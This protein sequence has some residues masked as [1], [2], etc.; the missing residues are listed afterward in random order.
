[1]AI[2]EAK[3]CSGLEC[4]MS[5]LT[6]VTVTLFQHCASCISKEV[7]RII[8]IGWW[9][10]LKSNSTLAIFFRRISS[11][12][13]QLG[14]L[15][16]CVWVIRVELFALRVAFDIQMFTDWFLACQ[17]HCQVPKHSSLIVW[18]TEGQYGY[19]VLKMIICAAIS[20]IGLQWKCECSTKWPKTEQKKI[21]QLNAIL[22]Q[23][24]T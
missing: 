19:G 15:V 5:F 14:G 12:H 10:K 17:T 13:V 8:F 7:R 3:I 4:L 22:W 9:T 23:S 2:S 11:V 16:I 24:A 20:T 1:M 18:S 6:A 21:W